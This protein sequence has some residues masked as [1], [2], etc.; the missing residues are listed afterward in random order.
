MQL[1]AFL[2]AQAE[3]VYRQ[4]QALLCESGGFALVF[5]ALVGYYAL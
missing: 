3:S 1:I 2:H 5:A 4:F